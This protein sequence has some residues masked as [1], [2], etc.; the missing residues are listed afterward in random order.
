MP[1]RFRRLFT[2]ALRSI[3]R[4]AALP[5]Y[6][7]PPWILGAQYAAADRYAKLAYDSLRN[8]TRAQLS[9]RRAARLAH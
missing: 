7:A 6:D 4:C 3:R 9:L 8:A 2:A 1:Q 5:W